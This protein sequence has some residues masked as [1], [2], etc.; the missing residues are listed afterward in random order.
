MNHEILYAALILL[1]IIPAIFAFVFLLKKLTYSSYQNASGIKVI[2][3]L[4][5]S[6]REK[7]VVISVENVKLVIGF[8]PNTF[9][10]LHLIEQND[11]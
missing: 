9:S 10:L 5:L 3:Q 4:S 1:L 7:I 2:H 11:I 6:K 8:S